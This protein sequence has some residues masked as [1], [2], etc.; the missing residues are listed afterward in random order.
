MWAVRPAQDLYLI[1]GSGVYKVNEEKMEQSEESKSL[2]V[3]SKFKRE[4]LQ[5]IKEDTNSSNCLKMFTSKNRLDTAL[6]F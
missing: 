1:S 3:N 4:I 6:I 2:N 5:I